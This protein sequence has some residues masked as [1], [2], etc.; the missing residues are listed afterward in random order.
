MADLVDVEREIEAKRVKINVDDLISA[1]KAVI[2]SRCQMAVKRIAAH[3]KN[4]SAIDQA[5]GRRDLL[6]LLRVCTFNTPMFHSGLSV[7]NL[8][9]AWG[10]NPDVTVLGP[11]LELASSFNA[12]VPADAKTVKIIFG[13]G[14]HL[15]I[16]GVYSLSDCNIRE[17]TPEQR[18]HVSDDFGLPEAFTSLNE[19]KA[20]A[21]THLHGEETAPAFFK[22][23]A[24][25]ALN[26]NQELSD[27]KKAQYEPLLAQMLSYAFDGF[28]SLQKDLDLLP[29]S[30]DLTNFVMDD[31]N[32]LQGAFNTTIINIRENLKAVKESL[33]YERIYRTRSIFSR[34]G[35]VDQRAGSENSQGAE[36]QRASSD[37]SGSDS[38]NLA[39]SFKQSGVGSASLQKDA[40]SSVQRGERS[41]AG[42]DDGRRDLEREVTDGELG[43]SSGQNPGT[44]NPG[45]E[46][47]NPDGL[48]GSPEPDHADVVHSGRLSGR[49]VETK[50]HQEIRGRDDGL[51][52]DGSSGDDIQRNSGEALRPEVGQSGRTGS[53]D[54][55]RSEL[56]SATADPGRVRVGTRSTVSVA[57]NVSAGEDVL[58]DDPASG[59]NE[60]GRGSASVQ[61]DQGVLHDRGQT[62]LSGESDRAYERGAGMERHSDVAGS[63]NAQREDVGI[64]G[65][66]ERK[67]NSAN[68]NLGVHVAEVASVQ[69][70]GQR[71]GA[72]DLESVDG[73]KD[74]AGRDG[75]TDQGLSSVQGDQRRVEESAGSPGVAGDPEEG[76]GVLQ[77]SGAGDSEDLGSRA[78]GTQSSG[79]EAAETKLNGS[80]T[81]EFVKHDGVNAVIPD[82]PLD[83]NNEQSRFDQ[84]SFYESRKNAN[85]EAIRTLRKLE[86]ENRFDLTV[87]E[88]KSLAGFSGFGGFSSGYFTSDA[89]KKEFTDEGLSKDEIDGLASSVLTG[90]YTHTGII[91][92]IENKL[93]SFG[94][95]NAKV[96]EPSCGVGKFLGRMPKGLASE[97]T[98]VELDPVS[99]KIAERLYPQA[100]VINAGFQTTVA[101]N[102]YDLA[103]GNVPFGNFSVYDKNSPELSKLKIHN[104]F[105]HKAL[106][107][108]RPG[109]VVAFITSSYTLDSIDEKNRRDLAGKAEFLGAVRLPSAAFKHSDTDVGTD[110]IFLQKRAHELDPAMINPDDPKFVWIKSEQKEYIELKIPDRVPHSSCVLKENAST[111]KVWINSYFVTHPEMI[112]GVMTAAKDRYGVFKPVCRAGEIR[113]SEFNDA[114]IFYSNNYLT[115]SGINKLKE[116]L[117]NIHCSSIENTA[118]NAT[119]VR[120]E[121]VDSDVLKSK[122][123]IQASPFTFFI[124][125]QGELLYKERHGFMPKVV[126]TNKDDISDPDKIYV[127]KNNLP[128]AC[129]LVTIRYQLDKI[130]RMEHDDVDP[131]QIMPERKRLS[132]L[133]SGIR[134]DY[135]KR[136]ISDKRYWKEI[137][138]KAH[139]AILKYLASKLPQDISFNRLTTLE[140]QDKKGNLISLSPVFTKTDYPRHKAPDHAETVEDALTLSINQKGKIDPVYIAR[141]LRKAPDAVMNDLLSRKLVYRDPETIDLSSGKLDPMSGFVTADAYLSGNIYSKIEKAEKLMKEQLSPDDLDTYGAAFRSQIEDLKKN[142]P[143]KIDASQ[144]FIEPGAR[145]IPEEYYSEFLHELLKDD[146]GLHDNK[147]IKFNEATGNY[148]YSGKYDID[149]GVANTTTYGIN[150]DGWNA[151]PIFMKILN[152][153]PLIIYTSDPLTDKP[154]IDAEMTS[155][156]MGKAEKIRSAFLDWIFEDQDRKSKLVEIYNHTFNAIRP[157]RFDGSKLPF[158]GINPDITLRPHQKNAVMRTLIGGNALFGHVVGAGK[159]Y[160]M[161]AS[162]MEKIR[163]KLAH[164]AMFVCLRSTMTQMQEDFQ[165]LYPGVKILVPTANDKKNWGRF[166]QKVAYGDNQLILIPHEWLKDIPTS[167]EIAKDFYLKQIDKLEKMRENMPEGYA[168]NDRFSQKRALLLKIEKLKRD[169]EKYEEMYSDRMKNTFGL[170]F[171]DLG[172]DAL[173]VDEAHKFKNAEL[174]SIDPRLR[175]PANPSLNATDL[176]MKCRSLNQRFNNKAIVLATGTPLNNNLVDLYTM[177]NYI[178]RPALEAAGLD[179]LDA[180][181]ATF[182]VFGEKSEIDA[183]GQKM[184]MVTRLRSISNLPEA[185]TIFGEVA[186]IKT[187]QDLKGVAVLPKTKFHYV[188]IPATRYQRDVMKTFV[189][190]AAHIK[191]RSEDNMLAISN[192]GR[193]LSLDP[194]LY[195]PNC[196]EDPNDSNLKVNQLVERV[197]KIAKENPDQGQ[198]IF[199]DRGTPNNPTFNLYAEI[200]NKLVAAGMKSDEIAFIHDYNDKT[201]Q[202]LFD[203]F[204]DGKVK[205]ILGSTEKL[206]TGVNIQERLKAIHHLDINWKPSD[207]EQRNGR[208]I[209]QG[210]SNAEV[211][212]YFYIGNRTFDSFMF[213]TVMRKANSFNQ[214]LHAAI[215]GDS[216]ERTLNFDDGNDS[217]SYS[218][219]MS[220][221]TGNPLWNEQTELSAQIKNL[222]NQEKA[223][224]SQLNDAK[225]K[226]ERTIPQEII[227][228]GK[229]H[230]ALTEAAKVLDAHQSE[231]G[232]DGAGFSMTVFEQKFDQERLRFVRV[233]HTYTKRAE[234]R[235]ALTE[236]IRKNSEKPVKM[237][238]WAGIDIYVHTAPKF[239]ID[240][241]GNN[242]PYSAGY[243][244]FKLSDSSV[245][246]PSTENLL[247]EH[248]LTSNENN[249]NL[250]KITDAFQGLRAGVGKIAEEMKS[251]Q[252]DLKNTQ[253]FVANNQ[254]FSKSGEL[255]QKRQRLNEID[256]LLAKNGATE[257]PEFDPNEQVTETVIE[258]DPN[259][260]DPNFFNNAIKASETKQNEAEAQNE[261]VEVQEVQVQSAASEIKPSEMAAEFTEVKTD[262]AITT[263][264]EDLKEHSEDLNSE[265]LKQQ[266]A[267]SVIDQSPLDLENSL[268]A[269][270]GLKP[271]VEQNSA[272]P[273]TEIPKNLTELEQKYSNTNENSGLRR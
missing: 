65:S 1:S 174:A 236:A 31:L 233:P 157:R 48:S 23:L 143:S 121:N 164:K 142:I 270:M 169:L 102:V 253:L 4:K 232:K 203:N 152:K 196:P 56:G 41:G 33:N 250:S 215:H 175:L 87:D 149:M 191:N 106:K 75:L 198:A 39:A 264:P 193:N 100:H 131:A 76:Q 137:D 254:N 90:Y 124:N 194:R 84:F 126:S 28:S 265:Q 154:V 25:N 173:Y 89:V 192:D 133:Y 40:G 229:Q 214:V 160:A 263:Q 219:C 237:A 15:T 151:I 129:A 91:D 273:N 97:I 55:E 14:N 187:A 147:S 114:N 35:S 208:I 197:L 60:R 161:C 170:T 93:V 213:Q 83:D 245:D 162:A 109:G 20:Y 53:Q 120:K 249:Q 211:D 2:N 240:E 74:Q 210:N 251:L 258:Y 231:L 223:F 18:K 7:E 228:L 130:N 9:L 82:D 45:N 59:S 69:P 13:S 267:E 181:L 81:V 268:R 182:G 128:L 101:E 134:R 259:V 146:R 104:Y 218:E 190:R 103:V 71:G 113:F 221:A 212:V 36:T 79:S 42:A 148:V 86:K 117:G 238:S 206:G 47:S 64:S 58:R 176:Q 269:A 132:D 95:K 38:D 225:E 32:H 184:K 235:K 171:E 159:T 163:L 29:E 144:I 168:G 256:N 54:H 222:E 70:V 166:L 217:L 68:G 17:L 266:S 141:L 80:D 19:L 66:D 261:N 85:L 99:A 216:K 22:V 241:K 220:A 11:S 242:K 34:A 61:T 234:A 30:I 10:Q 202:T 167:I 188:K 27:S 21:K 111:G 8:V 252:N 118:V 12:D 246:I 63:G 88:Q 257:V 3:C 243:L 153:Q 136:C 43:L 165:K 209:R 145:W 98:A 24:K 116:C 204:N 199:C 78:G 26:E 96:L 67:D 16:D 195:D 107:E 224:Y 110:I 92:A 5:A 94:F 46:I 135:E 180:Y 112:A 239:L 200:K 186:D 179:T 189:A 227:R 62:G 205:I 139:K 72:P 140:K 248:V 155:A 37:R 119:Q 158:N 178:N 108:V 262:E 156:V 122:E 207:I 247:F 125:A 115:P 77:Q 150:Q 105:F 49:R 52:S 172:I 244:S 50:G 185:M 272:T 127:E 271:K 226:A 57:T 177:Q 260:Y 73:N 230:Q 6:S 138:P 123:Y 255:L 183:T 51:A 201:K 44:E